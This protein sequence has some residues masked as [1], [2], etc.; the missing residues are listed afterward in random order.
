MKTVSVIEVCKTL[1]VSIPA[2]IRKEMGIQKGDKLEPEY[3]VVTEN[4]KFLV[5]EIRYR[6][7]KE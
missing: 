1:Y 7:V 6:K 5:G 2:D 3:S 4:G